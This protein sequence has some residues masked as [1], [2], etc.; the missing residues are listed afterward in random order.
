MKFPRAAISTFR[1]VLLMTLLNVGKALRFNMTANMKLNE[2]L[3]RNSNED[4]ELGL[5]HK[6]NIFMMTAPRLIV[7]NKMELHLIIMRDLTL[8]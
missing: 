4:N 1:T 8:S 3:S 7:S 2:L 6:T 5:L